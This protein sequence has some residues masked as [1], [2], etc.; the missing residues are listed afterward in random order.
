MTHLRRKA[1]TVSI[2]LSLVGL[3]FV[4]MLA[5]IAPQLEHVMY[6]GKYAT[7]AWLIPVLA[8]I[9]VA[10]GLATGFSMALRASQ[11]PHYDLISNAVA[12]PV[13]V[14]SAIFF[15]HWWGLVGAAASMILSF[16]ATSAVI[17]LCYRH[18]TS[19]V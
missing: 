11:K 14:V 18:F 10:T 6:S 9:P 2:G 12:A 16:F 5:V 4:A 15:L 19:G 17:L 7:Q 8:L 1:A 13:A 3:A